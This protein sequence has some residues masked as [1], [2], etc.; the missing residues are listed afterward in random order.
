MQVGFVCCDGTKR[1]LRRVYPARR[2][3]PMPVDGGA[4][5]GDGWQRARAEGS[6]DH[7]RASG[8]PQSHGV[9]E[10]AG[11]LR[12]PRERRMPSGGDRCFIICWMV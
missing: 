6:S 8:M 12:V 10:D 7:H 5:C 1:T 2:R 3:A 11:L 9:E 4:P